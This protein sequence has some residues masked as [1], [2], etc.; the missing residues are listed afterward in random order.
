MCTIYVRACV[1]CFC[2]FSNKPILYKR[3]S[4]RILS[5]INYFIFKIILFIITNVIIKK[6]KCIS[7]KI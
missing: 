4:Y 1:F 7:W 6:K 5:L 3:V 2:I